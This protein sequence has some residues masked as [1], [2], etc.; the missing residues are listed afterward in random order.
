MSTL[1]GNTR[2]THIRIGGNFKGRLVNEFDILGI[3]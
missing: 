3:F 2:R 1:K